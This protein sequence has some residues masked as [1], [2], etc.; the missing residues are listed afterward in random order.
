MKSVQFVNCSVN[1]DLKVEIKMHI[2]GFKP[3]PGIVLNLSQ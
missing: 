2:T 3:G 1:L